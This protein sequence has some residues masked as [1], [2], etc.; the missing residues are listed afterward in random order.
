MFEVFRSAAEVQAV[1]VE[2]GWP[3]CFIGGIVVQRWGEPRTTVDA[4]LTILAAFGSEG[5]IT[6]TLLKHFDAR[7][8]DAESFAA[9]HR[10]LL[11]RS[12][13]GVGIDVAFGA[14]PL[15]FDMIKRS[16]MF[17]FAPGLSLRTCSAEDLIVL[18]AFASRGQ[19]WVDV[20]K[21][22]IR[23]AG[24]LDWEYIDEQLAPLVELKEEPEIL[25]RLRQIR[26]RHDR[27][28]Q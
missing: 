10:V 24:G 1:C 2:Q 9:Q 5:S 27:S 13:V 4:D 7:I 16:S 20:E 17:T 6:A 12:T 3:Y 26:T 19:D 25:A 8:P 22:V 11:L 18:K 28:G 23:Q 15:E 14:L 21:V